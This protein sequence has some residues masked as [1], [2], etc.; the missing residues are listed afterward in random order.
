MAFETGTDVMVGLRIG[1]EPG[2]ALLRAVG[3]DGQMAHGFNI[4]REL[5][6]RLRGPVPPEVIAWVEREV[7]GG[8]VEQ[9]PLEGG[10]SAAIHRLILDRGKDLVV[11]RFVLDWISE[12]P[13]VPANEALVLE[14]LA[15][16][17]VPTPRLVSADPAGALMGVPTVLMTALP[18]HVVWDPQD[19]D[20]WIDALV[21]ILMTI[22][23]TEVTGSLRSWEA[24]AP[25]QVPPVWTQHRWAWER[26]IAAYEDDRPASDRVFLHRDFHPGNILW[27]N[28][29]I[30]GVVD[31]TS[32]C[33]GPP[34]ED[35][36][37]CRVNLAGHH[38]QA[39]ADRFLDRWM[40]ATGRT[41]YH[42][43]WD[44]LDVVSM[45]GSQP[46]PRLD[47]FVASA[48]ARL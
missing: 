9:E 22:H 44:L 26:A 12:E 42:P 7:G 31:W 32:S 16:T 17:Q 8:V 47:E 21:S 15:D 19:L 18:D 34:E 2:G 28:G 39:I 33:A 6:Q 23:Q 3:H 43:Y 20:A 35:V 25:E 11:Q 30:S 1:A 48:A 36:A 29:R 10:R 37:H 27:A 13:W 24:Y 46:D 4:E 5:H 38:G 45:G 14:L 40:Q 41:E